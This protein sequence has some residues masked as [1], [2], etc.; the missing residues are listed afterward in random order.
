MTRAGDP[1]S[2][3]ERYV[4][5]FESFAGNG[6]SGAP[7]WLKTKRESAISRFAETGFPH[8]RLEAWRFTDVKPIAGEHFVL[9]AKPEVSAA[10]RQAADAQLLGGAERH[11]AVFLNGHFVPELSS[12]EGLPQGVKL[13]SLRAALE[14]D[15]K[16]V[17]EH[18]TRYARDERNPLTALSTAFISDGGFAYIP[19]DVV[20][21]RPLQLLFLADPASGSNPMWHPR[22]LIVA[23]RG[24]GGSLVE[25]YVALG[26]GTYWTNAVTEVVL[27]E[28]AKIDTY[29]VQRESVQAYHTA[30]TESYQA[31]G[32]VFKLVN[33]TFG[34]ELS[35]QDINAV[36]DG[37]GAD[38]T[39]DGLSMLEGRQH[40]DHHTTLEHA[41]PHCTSW[42]YFNGVFDDRARGVF[43]GR[44]IV[45]PGAQ[46]TDSKQTNNNLLLSE[47]ARADSQP[48]LEI[49]A[50]DVK[51]THGATLGPIDDEHL[52]YLQSRGLSRQE[53]RHLLTYGFGSEILEAV[54]LDRLKEQLDGMVRDRLSG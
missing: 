39:L 1:K 28:H 23:G 20:L 2:A 25:S 4:A 22:T 46:Q 5:A 26:D 42:E 6:A 7:G 52:F 37:E 38:C 49:Y 47:R 30:T 44:I 12:L 27:G 18:L 8:S 54:K 51:C 31:R 53:A 35:R 36:L 32:S 10:I 45:R 43:T 50:D 9:A 19:D 40:T 16:L 29:R 41:Q 11:A 15:A 21:E 13:G 24:A 33:F 3:T 48:Q 14:S 34:A 17:E